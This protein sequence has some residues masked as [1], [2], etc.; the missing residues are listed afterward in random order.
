MIGGPESKAHLAEISRLAAP[1]SYPFGAS[2][3]TATIRRVAPRDTIWVIEA[4]TNTSFIADQ[5]QGPLHGSWINC[6]GGGLGW[7]GGGEE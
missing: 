5:I 6:G 7:P 2:F 1:T 3:A 4:V